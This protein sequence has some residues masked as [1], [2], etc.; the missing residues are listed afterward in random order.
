VVTVPAATGTGTGRA[1]RSGDRQRRELVLPA[2]NGKVASFI[3]ATED[4]AIAAW[5]GSVA[6]S[7]AV[8][9][10]N[11]SS[12]GAV[13]KG[14]GSNPTGSTPMLYAANFNSGNID[15]FDANFAPTTGHREIYGSES[16]EW[17]RAVQHLETSAGKCT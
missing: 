17:I 7:T 12:S 11:N 4:G 1:D 13:Y 2:P 9:V 14:L 6:N 5:N 10:V 16:A 8:I 15:V 3:F